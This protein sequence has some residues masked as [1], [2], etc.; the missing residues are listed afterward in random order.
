LILAPNNFQPS[1]RFS[2]SLS[3]SLSLSSHIIRRYGNLID[4]APSLHV[5]HSQYAKLSEDS[6]KVLA[7]VYQ[8][9]YFMLCLY[10]GVAMVRAYKAW[11]MSGGGSGGLG[12]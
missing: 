12:F 2:P 6:Q 9:T 7:A 4:P 5:S 11:Y 8:A 1:C 10:V 3:L